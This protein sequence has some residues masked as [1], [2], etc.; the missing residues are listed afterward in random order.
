MK[1]VDLS[2]DEKGYSYDSEPLSVPLTEEQIKG[3]MEIV[4]MITKPPMEYI[5][6]TLS[7]VLNVE[8][9][10]IYI[11]IDVAKGRIGTTIMTGEDV[12]MAI[13][14]LEQA[15]ARMRQVQKKEGN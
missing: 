14:A 2:D 9:K 7:L 10:S 11:A 4:K 3:G 12:N 13:S 8:V 1:R 5:E 6:K 15:L